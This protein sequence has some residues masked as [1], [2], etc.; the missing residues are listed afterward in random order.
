VTATLLLVV[1]TAVHAGFQVTVTVLVYPALART[2]AADWTAVHGE[3]ARRITPLVA[4]AYGMLVVAGVATVVAGPE[5]PATWVALAASAVAMLVT[6]TAAAPLHG[7][8]SDCPDPRLLARLLRV[9]RVRAV[10]ALVALAA[11]T[12]AAWQ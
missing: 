5:G 11:A 1:A 9:D 12:L 8:M 4:A 7:R 2:G 3:H 6:A 10:A